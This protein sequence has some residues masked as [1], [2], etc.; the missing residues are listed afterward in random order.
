MGDTFLIPRRLNVRSKNSLVSF[1]MLCDIRLQIPGFSLPTIRRVADAAG[2][3]DG[4][5]GIGQR[6][7]RVPGRSI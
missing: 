6:S 1:I 5:V 4:L 7:E 3:E 2:E